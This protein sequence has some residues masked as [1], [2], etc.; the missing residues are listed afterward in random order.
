MAYGEV[1]KK[2]TEEAMMW[3]VAIKSVI[4]VDE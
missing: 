2:N 3:K 1:L 4:K